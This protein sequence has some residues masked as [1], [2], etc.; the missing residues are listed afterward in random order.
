[1]E[2][3]RVKPNSA[4]TR[5]TPVCEAGIGRPPPVERLRVKLVVVGQGLGGIAEGPH[6]NA[7]V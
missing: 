3:L 4:G 5:G 6:W 1:M 7:C 2:R